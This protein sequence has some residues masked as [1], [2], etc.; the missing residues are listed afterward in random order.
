[1]RWFET[2]HSCVLGSNGPSLRLDDEAVVPSD[3]VQ[4][5]GVFFSSDLSLDKHVTAVS[6]ACSPAQ[7]SP[8]ITGRRLY[9]DARA[10]IRHVAGGLL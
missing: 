1:M 6:A 4:V 2:S 5:L 8:T 3:H 10:R 9:K 7:T